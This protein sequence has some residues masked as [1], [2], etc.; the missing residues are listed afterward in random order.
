MGRAV[1]KP[2]Y[3]GVENRGS[4]TTLL[5]GRTVGRREGRVALE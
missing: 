4:S 3:W 5:S 2:T 1:A